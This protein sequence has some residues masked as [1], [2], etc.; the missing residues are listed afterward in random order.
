MN[1]GVK[2]RDISILPSTV[3]TLPILE[4]RLITIA[5]SAQSSALSSMPANERR[6][7]RARESDLEARQEWPETT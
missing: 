4:N 3:P 6:S 2:V 7:D 5:Y 1:I